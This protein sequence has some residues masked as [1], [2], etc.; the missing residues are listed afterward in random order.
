MA[1]VR[2]KPLSRGK[3]RGFFVDMDGRQKLFTGTR[4]KAET[5]RIAKRLEDEHR[6]IRLGY[7]PAPVAADT[8]RTR[9]IAEAMEEYLAWG[10]S[11]GG[12][13]GRPWAKAHAYNREAK[14]TWWRERLSLETLADMDGILPRVEEALRGLQADGRAGNTL[15]K[16]SDALT[17][18]CYWCKGRGYLAQYPLDGLVPFDTT[19]KTKRRA[20][21]PEEI[22]ALLDS[23]APHRRLAYEVAC[24][25]GLRANE[26]RALT[27]AHLDAR[28]GGL[29]LDAAWTK[30]RRPGFQP[31]PA[32]LVERLQAFAKSGQTNRL[33]HSAYACTGADPNDAPPDPLLY[34]PSHPGRDM[35]ADLKAAGIQRWTPDGKLDFHALRVAYVT[36]VIESGASAKEAQELA[37][38]GTLD[39]TMHTYARAR[40]ERLHEVAESVA[41]IMEYVPEQA[42][43]RH[44]RAAG[45]EGIDVSVCDSNVLEH[46]GGA[47]GSS[48]GRSSRRPGHNPRGG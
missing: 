45:A 41:G 23:C 29:R 27:P 20:M 37:R 8:H 43:T 16:Y 13:G 7:R 28:R 15:Q 36:M 4:S 44:K 12:R 31:L 19:P 32:D 42:H 1:G 9:P 11:Q 3:F 34:V 22:R 38:H 48:A 21:T 6:Q 2:S 26:L 40:G 35:M 39:L 5:L 24:L 33:Y 30:N 10:R 17:A 47:R 46:V 14:L 25:S 18:F